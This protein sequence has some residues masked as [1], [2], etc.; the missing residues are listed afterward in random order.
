LRA[1]GL[2][3]SRATVTLRAVELLRA[4]TTQAALP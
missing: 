1:E 3:V 4:R 2:P